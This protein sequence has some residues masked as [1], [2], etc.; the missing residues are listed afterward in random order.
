M[1]CTLNSAKRSMKILTFAQSIDAHIQSVDNKR[2]LL[3]QVQQFLDGSNFEPA[4]V[5]DKLAEALYLPEIQKHQNTLPRSIRERAG[6][7]EV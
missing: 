5:T 3:E 4:W 2:S 7:Y 6:I 1:I